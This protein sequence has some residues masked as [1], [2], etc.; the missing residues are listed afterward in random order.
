MT[1]PKKDNGHTVEQKKTNVFKSKFTK[2]AELLVS[3]LTISVWFTA[4][5]L[6]AAGL[7]QLMHTLEAMRWL[8]GWKVD[9]GHFVENCIFV[10]DCISLVYAVFKE[11]WEH[12]LQHVV[13][14]VKGLF[15]DS[16]DSEDEDE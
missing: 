8:T 12:V 7:G 14:G 10:G 16:K 15:K 1:K 4:I 6:L 2:L 9:A 11:L 5:L 13:H 3:L